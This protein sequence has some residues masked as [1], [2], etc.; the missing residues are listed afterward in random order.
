MQSRQ[1]REYLKSICKSWYKDSS[2]F[3]VGTSKFTIKKLNT[4]KFY[5]QLQIGL[6]YLEQVQEYKS[7]HIVYLY[8]QYVQRVWI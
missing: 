8:T 5:K 3:E 4:L 6:L 7:V 1:I 2:S